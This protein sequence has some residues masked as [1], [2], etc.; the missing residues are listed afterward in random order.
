MKISI[1]LTKIP[2]L[3]CQQIT[4]F[5]LILHHEVVRKNRT[6]AVLEEVTSHLQNLQKHNKN[7][8]VANN[9]YN[10]IHMC[11][12]LPKDVSESDKLFFS[13]I[14]ET[15]KLEDTALV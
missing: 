10:R 9:S 7:I 8:N 14:E 6:W 2:V 5:L 11:M 3:G 4:A 1:E 15:F 13:P 12:C